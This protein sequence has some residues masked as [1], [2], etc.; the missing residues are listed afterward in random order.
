M[1]IFPADSPWL[2]CRTITL[3]ELAKN[4]VKRSRQ[5]E[6]YLPSAMLFEACQ[7]SQTTILTAN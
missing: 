3:D 5:I 1:R 6:S 7:V 4:C 2:N